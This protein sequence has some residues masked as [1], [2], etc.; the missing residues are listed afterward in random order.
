MFPGLK[1]APVCQQT[2]VIKKAVSETERRRKIQEAYNKK[3][4]I[5]PQTI[6]KSR[7]EIIKATSFADAKSVVPEK[8]ADQE[9][10]AVALLEYEE[11]MRVL[12]R[13]MKK[14][15]K[16]LQFEKAAQLRDE[17]SKLRKA[18]KK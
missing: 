8:S 5:D 10:D 14:A 6:I 1:P 17:L 12:E 18:V 9:I 15:A 3:H 13:M 4:G 16:D 2:D 11:R 7:D